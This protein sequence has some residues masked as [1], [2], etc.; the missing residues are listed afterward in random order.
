MSGT[1]QTLILP[2]VRF[3]PRAFCEA[4]GKCKRCRVLDI[5]HSAK[6]L[7][8]GIR[9]VSGSVIDPGRRSAHAMH[10]VELHA[11]ERALLAIRTSPRSESRVL[12]ETRSPVLIQA[13]RSSASAATGLWLAHPCNYQHMPTRRAWPM[14]TR[15]TR[16][17]TRAML[18]SHTH[19][20]ELVR[21]CYS[22]DSTN[23]C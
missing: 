19:E 12:R 18:P 4:L 11:H 14:W 13:A 2:S 9:V 17:H 15:T 1:R 3:L 6:S 23:T 7:A 10:S 8:L 22:T 21:V 16:A 5:M 20:H